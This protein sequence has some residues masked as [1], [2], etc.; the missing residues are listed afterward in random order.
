MTL[1]NLTQRVKKGRKKRAKGSK[2]PDPLGGSNSITVRQS[3]IEESVDRLGSN[4]E[5]SVVEQ[6][7]D[8]RD[9]KLKEGK[10][11]RKKSKKKRNQKHNSAATSAVRDFLDKSMPLELKQYIL[12]NY[13]TSYGSPLNL[14]VTHSRSILAG[15][16]ASARSK[17]SEKPKRASG[18]TNIQTEEIVLAH[19]KLGNVT[20]VMTIP[21]EATK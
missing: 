20:P 14:V 9:S 5:G 6:N 19:G 2:S 1:G 3:S 7:T 18:E 8:T 10:S 16:K 21:A 17:V 13:G 12:A 15:P 11:A 4:M